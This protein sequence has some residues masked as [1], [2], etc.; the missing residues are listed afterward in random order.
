MKKTFSLMVLLLT[1]C[2]I[3][4]AQYMLKVQYTNGT[5]DLYEID[6]TEGIEW[7]KDYGNPNRAYMSVNGRLAGQHNTFAMGYPT[8]MIQEVTVV[9][10]EPAA[11]PATE[12]NTFD[13]DEQ[14]A[15]INMVNYSIEFGPSCIEGQKK[16]TV[17]R[18]D[19][20][21]APEGFEDGVNYMST[22]DFD[23]EG[24]HDLNGV[25]EIRFPVTKQCY[26]AYLN[27]ETGEW[28]PVLSY[29]DGKTREMVIITDH[30]S[31]YG[32]FDVDNEHTRA[33]KLEYSS[34]DPLKPTDIEK[35][36]GLLSKIA[37]S[38]NPTIAAIDEFANNEYF[39]ASTGVT[40]TAPILQ[41]LGVDSKFVEGYSDI[42][43]KIGTAWSI[44]SF[45]N[46]LC[47]NDDQAK[48]VSATKLAFD[49]VGKK[50]LEEKL[51]AGNFLFPACMTALAVLDWE[52]N[53]FATTVHGT[54]TSLYEDA[55]RKY[56]RPNSGYPS[57]GGYGYRSSEEWYKLINPF[58]VDRSREP[59]EVTRE[60]ED[61]VTDYVNQ[62]WHDNDGFTWAIADSRGWWPFWVEITD[63]DRQVI[64]DTHRKELYTG[65]LKSVVHNINRKYLCKTKEKY[66]EVFTQYAKMMNKIVNLKFVDTEVK[67]GEKS[68]FAGCKIRFAKMP[69]TITDPE[70][71]ECVVNDDGKCYIQFRM[72]PYC[73]EGFEPELE[74]VDAEDM[75]VGNIT[76]EGIQDIG[77]YYE[78]TFDLSKKELL[79]MEDKW[80]IKL[81]PNK[82]LI[83][84]VT[85][86]SIPR[87]FSPLIYPDDQGWERIS[88][89]EHYVPG[90]VHGIL[91]GIAEAFEDRT[92]NLDEEGNFSISN[93]HLT[94]T[95]NV[96][97]KIGYGT[98]K[99]T[100]KA[101]SSGSHFVSEFDAFD[102]WYQW[103]V[104]YQ[105][106]QHGPRPVDKCWTT[107]EEFNANFSV[108][109]TLE[110]RYSDM[111]KCYAVHLDGIGSFNFS[112]E[113]YGDAKRYE[114]VQ[115]E[116]GI[117]IL[118]YHSKQMNTM[119][120]AVEDGQ[121]IF[122]PTLVYE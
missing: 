80:D 50:Y 17:S 27:Q 113:A 109:G 87:Y 79:D 19:N 60:I 51:F 100:L 65:T 64:A 25:V 20:A 118:K 6:C 81:D 73:T 22:Y 62:P 33:A 30:L 23:L 21:K 52:I 105:G 4:H 121:L 37:E 97:R 32:V 69:T 114:W 71:W 46:T 75:Y 83:D 5:H 76:I 58:F 14:T 2:G 101:H 89:A 110:I 120:M 112:G 55:Y 28:K 68:R 57:I 16:L 116:E 56:F 119:D 38:D 103:A 111:M 45:A 86:D 98:G 95:G 35:V 77:K 117:L 66:D 18:I 102:D 72:F 12:Q 53:W 54:A 88:V 90:D 26:A 49:L 59:E 24:I 8:D 84:V 44:M 9:S 78:V 40:V 99:F 104:W 74:V 92:L 96:N 15:S 93:S 115:N 91:N 61:I 31:T 34:Y 107:M 3:A 39:W 36:A 82:A 94:M 29:Y 67:K 122:S 85:A 41:T 42:V 7:S 11:P 106:G 70:K 108:G 13:V 47:G 1:V 63:K 43:G 10:A 48:A